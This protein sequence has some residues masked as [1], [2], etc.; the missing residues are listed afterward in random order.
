MVDGR[1][2]LTG[3]RVNPGSGE[4]N[5]GPRSPSRLEAPGAGA[6]GERG[7][8]ALC[9]GMPWR[10]RCAGAILAFIACSGCSSGSDDADD[11]GSTVS[12]SS[13]PRLDTY[14]GGL[15][16][17]GELGV[18]SFHFSDITPDPPA[19]GSNTFHVQVSDASGAAM[20]GKLGVDLNMPDHGHGTSV[21]PVSTLDPATG[22]FTV[23]PLYLFMPGVW[24]IRFDAYAADTDAS[25]LDSVTLHFCVEG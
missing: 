13:D 19:K 7:A 5:T 20:Q 6:A 2:A 25:P 9:S 23:T 3:N 18:L 17:P 24:R 11:P 15:N 22:S 12:C 8:C 10:F 16:K 1:V 4:S 21:K 14:A